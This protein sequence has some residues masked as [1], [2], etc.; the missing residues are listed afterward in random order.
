MTDL[1]ILRIRSCSLEQRRRVHH[2]AVRDWINGVGAKTAFIEAASPRANGYCESFNSNL[3]E[4]LLN[5]E[6]H[7]LAEALRRDRDKARPLQCRAPIRRWVL[8]AS[9]LVPWPA[10]HQDPNQT[11]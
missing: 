10:M 9:T 11:T 3:R 4:K 5:G 1:F 6:I 2:Q 7:F 8:P